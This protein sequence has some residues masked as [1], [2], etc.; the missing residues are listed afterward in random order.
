MSTEQIET[1]K[2]AQK[3]EEAHL[4]I[5][6]AVLSQMAED[7]ELNHDA[8]AERAGVA[9][10]TVYRYFPDREALLSAAWLRMTQ[11]AGPGVAFPTSEAD[12]TDSLGAI[13]RGFDQNAELQTILRA[14]L[15][16]RA[17]RL[18][19]REERVA[20]YQAAAAAAVAALPKE[21]QRLATAMLQVLHTGPWLEMRDQWGLDG[22]SIATA[23]EWAIRVLLQDLR[24]RGARPLSEGPAPP[25]TLE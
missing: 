20:S 24:E 10:R 22:A 18:S 15:R 3:K 13:H 17:I 9:R 14:T 8:V 1:G 5:V 23:C 16:G 12:L 19:R 11:L 4:R 25:L 2:R 6:D 7:G 21:D